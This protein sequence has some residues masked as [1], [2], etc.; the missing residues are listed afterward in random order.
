[1]ELAAVGVSIAVFNQVSRITIF[2]LVS[3]T[4]SFVAEEDAI[5]RLTAEAH[6]DGKLEKDFAPNEEMEKLI[7]Q[8]GMFSIFFY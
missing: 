1:M 8:V 6:E 7:P 2:P 4:T 3:V 5:G